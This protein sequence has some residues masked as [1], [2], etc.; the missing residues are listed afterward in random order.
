MRRG[1]ISL[2]AAMGVAAS[3]SAAAAQEVSF[4]L[5]LI[6][7]EA[8]ASSCA[9]IFDAQNKLGV[10]LGEIKVQIIGLAA[11][12]VYEGLWLLSFSNIKDKKRQIKSFELPKSC[13]EIGKFNVN[14]FTEC[15]GDKDYKDLCNKGLRASSKVENVGFSNEAE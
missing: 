11:S 6:G 14:F 15:K 10:D 8:K 12:G 3:A 1:A 13:N 9:F 4:T 2:V 5:D 7:R